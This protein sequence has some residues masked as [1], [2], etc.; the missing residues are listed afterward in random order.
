MKDIRISTPT[1]SDFRAAPEPRVSTLARVQAALDDELP[2]HPAHQRRESHLFTGW[3]W[4][5]FATTFHALG[6]S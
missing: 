3:L 4:L 5:G 1:G 2:M 6:R